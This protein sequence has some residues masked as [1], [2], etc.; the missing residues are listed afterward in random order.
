VWKPTLLPIPEAGL[1]FKFKAA[2]Q[3]GG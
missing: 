2:M 3:N 1:K